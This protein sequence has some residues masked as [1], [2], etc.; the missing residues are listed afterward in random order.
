MVLLMLLSSRVD[1]STLFLM[2]HALS[3]VGEA[4]VRATCSI[5][6]YL[7][8][9]KIERGMLNMHRLPEPPPA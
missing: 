5:C 8:G 2:K 9:S 6:S 7:R 1:V 4:R 3:A